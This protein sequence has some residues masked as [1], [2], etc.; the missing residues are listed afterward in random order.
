MRRSRTQWPWG[1]GLTD[2][3]DLDGPAESSGDGDIPKACRRALVQPC[4]ANPS[5]SMVSAAI[6]VW[7]VSHPLPP[8][9]GI[10]VLRGGTVNV[11]ISHDFH[12]VS[13]GSLPATSRFTPET[14]SGRVSTIFSDVSEQLLVE[15]D[16]LNLK[17][18]AALFRRTLP[19]PA[20]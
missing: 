6:D 15:I 9:E 5:W 19:E 7:Y 4:T 13:S 1:S 2:L 11:A 14:V 3:V 18:A 8:G 16:G 17:A 20:V 10:N 12:S